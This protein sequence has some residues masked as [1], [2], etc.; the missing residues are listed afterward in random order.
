MIIIDRLKAFITRS[1]PASTW[2]FGAMILLIVIALLMT[3]Q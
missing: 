2:F 1:Y 3:L